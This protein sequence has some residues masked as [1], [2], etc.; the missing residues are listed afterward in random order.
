M[1]EEK[2]TNDIIEKWRE[3][4]G[5]PDYLVSDQ[6]RVKALN[7]RNKGKECILSP[8]G[9]GYKTVSIHGKNCYVHR[10]VA[11]AF[12]PNPENKSDVNH[13]NCDTNDN[14]VTNLEWTTRDENISAYFKSDKYKQYLEEQRRIYREQRRNKY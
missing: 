8:G 10:L 12:I 14:R 1:A 2:V 3:V 9:Q 4:E 13:I 11:K 7:Y 5:A 6:G